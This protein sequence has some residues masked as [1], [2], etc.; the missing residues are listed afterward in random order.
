MQFVPRY[1]PDAR[2]ASDDGAPALEIMPRRLAPPVQPQTGAG[3]AALFTDVPLQ[4]STDF[5]GIF[6][7]SVIPPNPS[8]AAG[9]DH[10]LALTNGTVAVF[11]K[12]GSI[13]SL[14]GL[15]DFFQSV[16][17]PDDFITDPRTLFDS[18]RFFVSVASQ[19]S[20]PFAAFFL[21]AVSASSDPTGAWNF[22]A[23]DAATDNATPT[24]NFADLPG[25]GRRRQRHLPHRE[26][27]RRQP[28]SSS[29]GRRSAS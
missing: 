25:A 24:N 26:H 17:A 13:V 27:V 9:P 12:D 2:P 14:S 15:P 6:F 18:G 20:N 19:R 23:L 10:I 7:D 1:D 3:G 5:A 29:R 4:A 8:I 11:L 22:Y 16:A 28:A 21:L